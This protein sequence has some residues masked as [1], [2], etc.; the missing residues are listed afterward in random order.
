MIEYSNW[1]VSEPRQALQVAHGEQEEAGVD[2]LIGGYPPVN[3]GGITCGDLSAAW[4]VTNANSA[5]KR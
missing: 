3:N 2:I 5:V 1:V 4:L